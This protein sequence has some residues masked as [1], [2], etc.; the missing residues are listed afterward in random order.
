L[1]IY[2]SYAT[3]ALPPRKF[4]QKSIFAPDLM[5][6]ILLH[7]PDFSLAWPLKI[8]RKIRMFAQTPSTLTSEI[9]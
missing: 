7:N 9:N 8:S 2:F 1:V 3:S 4:N 5:S 6:L